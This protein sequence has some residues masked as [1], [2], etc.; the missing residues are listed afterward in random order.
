VNY[1]IAQVQLAVILNERYADL[2]ASL[3]DTLC[4]EEEGS[5]CNFVSHESRKIRCA[6][7]SKLHVCA[8]P[9]E[10]SLNSFKVVVVVV[11]VVLL[12]S[13]IRESDCLAN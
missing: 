10:E 4:L 5:N 13:L 6:Y 8:V 2:Q 9:T 3:V 7:S 12:S 11:V 1:G